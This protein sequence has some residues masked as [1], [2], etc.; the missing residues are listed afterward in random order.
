[1]ATTLTS[2]GQVT[3]P[4][5]IRDF[6]KVR[7]GDPIDFLIESEGRVLVR[8]SNADVR[9]LKGLLKR[10]GRKPVSLDAMEDAIG[11]HHGRLP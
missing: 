9:E 3:L 8:P 5:A 10:P 2:K 1:M 11:R 7:P 4:K 6:L